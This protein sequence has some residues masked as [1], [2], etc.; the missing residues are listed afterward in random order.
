MSNE[1]IEQIIKEN[2]IFSSK[3]QMVFVLCYVLPG[4]QGVD[5]GHG[6]T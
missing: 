4:D 3:T 6:D 2:I 1:N 5:G